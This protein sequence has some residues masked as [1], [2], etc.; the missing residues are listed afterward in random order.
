MDILIIKCGDCIHWVKQIKES[1]GECKFLTTK[2]ATTRS[3]DG[4]LGT[5][6]HKVVAYEDFGCASFERKE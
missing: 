2:V 3:A 5:F 6:E 1:K 4:F